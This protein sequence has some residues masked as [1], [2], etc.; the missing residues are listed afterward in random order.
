MIRRPPRSTQ[1]TTLFPYTTLF[2]SDP[3]ILTIGFARRFATYKRGALLFTDKNRLHKLLNDSTR[4]VQFIFAGKA[5]PRD[6]GGKA[7]IQEVYK[8]SRESG[9]DNRIVF[10]ED[11]DTYIA[12]RLVQG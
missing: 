7:L 11:Y 10:V 2:R 9:F 12:R 8:F 4:P 6:E 5:H 1:R 3:E